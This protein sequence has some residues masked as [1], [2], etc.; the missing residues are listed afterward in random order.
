MRKI[1]EKLLSTNPIQVEIFSDIQD[2]P[3]EPYTSD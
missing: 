3:V 1:Q 2:D